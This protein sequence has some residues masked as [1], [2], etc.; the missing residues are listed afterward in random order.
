MTT[1]KL[2]SIRFK[3]EVIQFVDDFRGQNTFSEAVNDVLQWLSQY[4]KAYAMRALGKKYENQV[5]AA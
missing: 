5:Q 2:K 4:G 3:P 1:R